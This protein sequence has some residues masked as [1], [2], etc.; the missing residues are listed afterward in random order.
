MEITPENNPIVFFPASGTGPRLFS[1]PAFFGFSLASFQDLMAGKKADPPKFGLSPQQEF[2]CIQKKPLP[3]YK[4][5][6]LT[7]NAVR[8]LR[9][10]LIRQ[11]DLEN[12]ADDLPEIHKE[13]IRYSKD[14]LEEI[15]REFNSSYGLEQTLEEIFRENLL[16]ADL[17]F[18]LDLLHG[19]YAP[20][21]IELTVCHPEEGK[22]TYAFQAVGKITQEELDFLGHWLCHFPTMILDGAVKTQYGSFFVPEPPLDFRFIPS[23]FWLTYLKAQTLDEKRAKRLAHA[24]GIYSG[25][26]NSIHLRTDQITT[27]RD[28]VAH[29]VAHYLADILVLG[30]GD[31]LDELGAVLVGH[32]L[33]RVAEHLAPKEQNELF[34]LIGLQIELAEKLIE[35]PPED[36]KRLKELANKV[37]RRII[38]C[39]RFPAVYPGNIVSYYALIGNQRESVVEYFA[40][41]LAYFIVHPEW[42]FLTDKQLYRA[43]YAFV[44]H[45]NRGEKEK[46]K[47]AFKTILSSAKKANL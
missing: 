14:Q 30:M 37:V 32:K 29:E 43:F 13:L 27:M 17:Q 44:Q 39:Y 25:A 22:N 28:L 33:K 47:E 8:K 34:D 42:L 36:Q 23:R 16:G 6:F 4:S 26:Y 19:Q 35:L 7:K 20:Y 15:E 31:L 12:I 10:K 41:N 40:E 18:T 45:L 9:I 21:S 24:S 5:S 2:I 11:G 46:A 3:E 1:P 38:P